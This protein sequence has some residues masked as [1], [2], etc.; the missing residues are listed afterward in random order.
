MTPK[1]QNIRGSKIDFLECVWSQMVLSYYGFKTSRYGYK[2][3]YMN[4]MVTRNQKMYNR[5]TRNIGGKKS[6][7]QQKIINP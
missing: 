3:T 2:T 6:I 5:Y 4:F 1:A 7:P